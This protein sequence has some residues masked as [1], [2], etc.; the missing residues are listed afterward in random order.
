M[1]NAPDIP[2][3]TRKALVTSLVQTHNGIVR[4]FRCPE[5]LLCA[6][7]PFGALIEEIGQL[8][9]VSPLIDAM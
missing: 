9:L 7:D 3:L 1:E 2:G 6:V 5:D 4:P 8:M